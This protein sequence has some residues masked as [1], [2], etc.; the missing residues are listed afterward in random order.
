M[1][2]L[3]SVRAVVYW[4]AWRGTLLDVAVQTNIAVG[5]A[6]IGFAATYGLMN[7]SRAV[8][9]SYEAAAPET[10]L[11][12]TP[13]MAVRNDAVLT[14]TQKTVTKEAAAGVL[15]FSFTAAD[16]TDDAPAIVFGFG[17]ISPLTG[18]PLKHLS[19]GNAGVIVEVYFYVLFLFIGLRRLFGDHFQAGVG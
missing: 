9:A 6:A 13:R 14:L 8:I 4:N 7:Q 3:L 5:Y 15:T 16:M 11:L 18:L 10:F 1:P 17:L 12:F 19:R 2:L